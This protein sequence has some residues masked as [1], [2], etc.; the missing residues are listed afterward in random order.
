MQATAPGWQVEGVPVQFP[1]Q[2]WEE[3]VQLTPSAEQLG[4][5]Q[6]AGLPVQLPEQQSVPLLQLVPLAKHCVGWQVLEVRPLQ[7]VEQHGVPLPTVQVA[8]LARQ[9]LA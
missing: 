1:E 4:A 6:V 8:P 3:L 9:V 7:K 5:W 2:H